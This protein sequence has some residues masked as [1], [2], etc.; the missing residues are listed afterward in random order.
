MKLVF[1][2]I[3]FLVF[4]KNLWTEEILPIRTQVGLTSQ[5]LQS[6]YVNREDST[7]E[8]FFLETRW[9]ENTNLFF[10]K[11][12]TRTLGSFEL[13]RKWFYTSIGHRYKPIS[14]FYFLRDVEFYSAFQNP[15]VAIV[16]QPIYQS[17][18]LGWNPFGF[19]GGIFLGQKFSE[20]QPGIY[21]HFPSQIFSFAYSKEQ[22]FYFASVNLRDWKLHPSSWLLTIRGE[23]IGK[24]E[25][26]I[27]Y[28]NTRLFFPT[29]G[30][31]FEFSGFR[32]GENG[33]LFSVTPDRF[34][35][36]NFTRSVFFRISRNF[37]DR[38]FFFR[39][40][41]ELGVSNIAE[42]NMSFFSLP[43]GALCLGTR[44]YSI[45]EINS[46]TTRQTLAGS[47]S[48]EWKKKGN[49]FQVRVENR[50]NTDKLA[51]LK[52]T[53]RPDR[54]WK[55]ELS[56]LFQ[57]KENEF[58]SFY[59]QWSDGENIN[60]ILTN[61]E[62]ALKVK[63]LSPNFALNLSGSRSQKGFETYFANIQFRMEF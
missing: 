53:F 40:W 33:N 3:V 62:T 55:I 58:H 54:V 37:Y 60:F 6:R 57:K 11:R 19:G 48:Y 14:G 29:S 9:K 49:E 23:G 26:Y 41:T 61:R 17:S 7:K 45:L 39:Q 21:F 15:E 50:K 10:E 18:F 32:E 52:F 31:D 4:I 63:V 16:E 27:G 30:F 13:K 28:L 8:N 42:G 1:R 43:L 51:E 12:E 36:E 34:R 35:D 20:K 25:A 5:T 56:S 38:I 47:I 22:E 2:S 46:Q 44:T 24:K 59:E